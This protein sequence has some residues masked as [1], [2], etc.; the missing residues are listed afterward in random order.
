MSNPTIIWTP[1]KSLQ[2]AEEFRSAHEQ[3][4]DLIEQWEHTIQMMQ[5]RD[6]E[7]DGLNEKLAS[8]RQRVTDKETTIRGRNLY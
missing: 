5:R 2:T 3:R 7:M 8:V 4:R 1:T 6:R